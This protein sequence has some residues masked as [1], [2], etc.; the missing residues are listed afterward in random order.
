MKSNVSD[1]LNLVQCIYI[2]ACAMCVAEVSDFRDLDCIRSRVEHEGLSFLTIILPTFATDLERAVTTGFIDST[3]FKNFKKVGPIPAFLQGMV[4][5]IFDRETGRFL[6]EKSPEDISVV[7]DAIRQICLAFKKIELPCTS[8]RTYK[9]I[10]RFIEIEHDF[11]KFSLS[12][13]DT[14]DFYSVSAVLWSSLASSIVLA[15]CSPR[16]G[17]GATSEGASGNQ[18]Y[19]WSEWND[20][21]EPYFPLVDSGY[22]LGLPSYSKEL[23]RTTIMSVAS[24]RPVRVVLVPKTLKSPRVIA[25]EPCCQMFVQQGIR[26][27]IYSALESS[28]WSKGHVNFRDQ[29]IN[30]ELAITGSST[31]QLATI[32]LSDASDRVPRDL[33]LG[34]FR[35]NPPLQEAI[36]A[37]RSTKALLPTGEILQ[38]LNKFASMGSALCFPI[39]AMYFYTVCV[40]A[41][42]RARSLS[43]TA[44]NIYKV[45]RDIYVYG[46]DLI[47]PS[48][49]ATIVLDYLQKYNC[50]VNAN[51][52]FVSGSFRESCGIDA[53]AGL[54]VTPVYLR[55]EFPENVRQ[56]GSVISWV[57]TANL[58]YKRGFWNTAS[59]M[60]NRIEELVGPLPYVSEKSPVVGHISYLG[61]QSVERWNGSLHSFEIKGYVPEPVYRPDVLEG[62]GALL[63]CFKRLESVFTDSDTDESL[64]TVKSSYALERIISR[65]ADTDARHLERSALRGAVAYKR[66]WAPALN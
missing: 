39:E 24:E 61:Y 54:P 26:D 15:D 8:A 5:L 35:C 58:F 28:C 49:N 55:H 40:V 63:K 12:T 33:A 66:R 34:M 65:I 4:S 57:A 38:P 20:R 2:D 52:T 10:L 37:C 62:Y 30:Q 42:L 16:H 50:K 18:K 14:D 1:H 43:F 11:S 51:K 23:E 48:T 60:R 9:A 41:L 7:L 59:F 31:G 29:T 22:P 17:P 36:D 47:V 19:Q 6:D 64:Q 3:A 45:S 13:A 56:H 25:I 46:D 53:Y 32:D 21:L 27:R 44:S